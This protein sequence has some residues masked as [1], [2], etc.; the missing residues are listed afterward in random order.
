ME[1]SHHSLEK[2]VSV[3]V[4][5]CVKYIHREC[6]SLS[7]FVLTLPSIDSLNA[8]IS[9]VLKKNRELSEIVYIITWMVKIHIIAGLIKKNALK[10][11]MS[12]CCFIF[13]W[14]MY[15]VWGEDT[16]F[17]K[18]L[19]LKLTPTSPWLSCTFAIHSL[20]T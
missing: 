3:W 17:L 14:F 6:D 15:S 7:H 16:I 12:Q 9:A 10:T 4:H 2:C 19:S 20:S 1:I 8:T 18:L 13:H 5:A 11:N